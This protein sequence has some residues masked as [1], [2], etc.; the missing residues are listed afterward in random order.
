MARVSVPEPK[1]GEDRP[2]TLAASPLTYLRATMIDT[3][4]SFREPKTIRKVLIGTA[5]ILV[6]IF[7][8][9]ARATHGA[10]HL[11]LG[12][13]LFVTY[14]AL[15]L[16]IGAFLARRRDRPLSPFEFVVVNKL[17]RW[18][19]FAGVFGLPVLLR[20]AGIPDDTSLRM[21][22]G[23]AV[24]MA[25]VFVG[26]IVWMLLARRM[27]RHVYR[28]T[29]FPRWTLRISLMT[30]AV[31]GAAVALDPGGWLR[32]ARDFVTMIHKTMS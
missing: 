12:L 31:I 28:P 22:I 24:G 25:V 21:L 8:A 30:S 29:K 20:I 2:P 13:G 10:V 15:G 16:A 19:L 4:R 5:I 3:A 9:A 27:P 6:A 11:V 7:T 32:V 26:S 17:A 14:G 23:F 18:L 1:P